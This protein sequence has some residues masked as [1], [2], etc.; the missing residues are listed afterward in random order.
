MLRASPLTSRA[1]VRAGALM[2]D[3][4]KY[5]PEIA[6]VTRAHLRICSNHARVRA[7]EARARMSL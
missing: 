5:Y 2:R 7:S 3:N 1:C 4:T 6:R